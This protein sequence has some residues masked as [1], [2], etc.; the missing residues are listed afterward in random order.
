M[1]GEDPLPA[2]TTAFSCPGLAARAL[3]SFSYENTDPTIDSSPKP[4]DGWQVPS[5]DA[6]VLL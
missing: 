2:L 4:V 5:P 6:V 1:S 3:V